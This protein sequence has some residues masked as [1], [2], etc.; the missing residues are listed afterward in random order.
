MLQ[1]GW[2][3]AGTDND[4]RVVLGPAA[5]EELD[6]K[7]GLAAKP[8]THPQWRRRGIVLC[9]N[10]TKHEHQRRLAVLPCNLRCHLKAPQLLGPHLWRP[11]QQ[12]SQIMAAQRLLGRPETLGRFVDIHPQ[13]RAACNALAIQCGQIRLM[14]TTDQHQNA[15][16]WCSAALFVL[17]MGDTGAGAGACSGTRHA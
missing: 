15:L 3:Q 17:G 10:G 1:Q 5:F 2:R 11:Q 6:F 14:G 8:Q 7:A 13:H 9:P 12:G 16:G 4:Q